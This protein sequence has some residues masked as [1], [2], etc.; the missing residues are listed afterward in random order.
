MIYVD[1][2]RSYNRKRGKWCHMMTDG[3][4][5][6]LHQFAVMIGLKRSWFQSQPSHPHYDLTLS[7]RAKA[8]QSGAIE[9]DSKTLVVKCGKQYQY[10]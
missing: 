3:P 10:R 2:P 6:E 4:I 1:T 7:F 8:V 5:E 9:V